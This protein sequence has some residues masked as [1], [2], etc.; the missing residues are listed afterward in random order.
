VSYIADLISRK[1]FLAYFIVGDKYTENDLGLS[2]ANLRIID[3]QTTDF[4]TYRFAFTTKIL[5]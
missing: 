2:T 4:P 3:S 5:L 1:T